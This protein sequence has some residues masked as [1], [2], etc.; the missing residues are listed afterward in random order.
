M[1]LVAEQIHDD[2]HQFMSKLAVLVGT[3]DKN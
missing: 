1:S 3:S 2:V